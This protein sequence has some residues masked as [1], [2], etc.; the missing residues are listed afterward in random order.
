MGANGHILKAVGEF[1][2]A[3]FEHPRAFFFR[4]QTPAI[5]TKLRGDIMNTKWRFS[6]QGLEQVTTPREERSCYLH[7]AVRYKSSIIIDFYTNKDFEG[8][9]TKDE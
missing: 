8:L 4:L 6:Y 3:L 5:Q 7:F 2:E 1:S 9:F